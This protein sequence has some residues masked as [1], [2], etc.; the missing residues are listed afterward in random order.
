MKETE[1]SIKEATFE[2]RSTYD[3]LAEMADSEIQIGFSALKTLASTLEIK[4]IAVGVDSEALYQKLELLG[5]TAMQ[6]NYI[7][8]PETFNE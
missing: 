1:A 4:L 5:I 3:Q 8:V 2:A 7:S 6:G